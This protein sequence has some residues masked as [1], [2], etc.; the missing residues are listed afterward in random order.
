MMKEKRFLVALGALSAALAACSSEVGSPGGD[1]MG[2]DDG[3]TPGAGNGSGGSGTA[4]PGAGNGPVGTGG[5]SLSSA[6]G[7]GTPGTGG[8]GATAGSGSPPLPVGDCKPGVP[9][10]TQ[11]PKL[12]NRQYESVVRDLLGVSGL[13]GDDLPGDF[14]GAM[15]A[16]AWQAY[17]KTAAKIAAQVMSGPNKSKFITC[18]PAAAG[19]L[20]TTI[21]TFGRKAFRRQLRAE[22]VQGFEALANTTPKGTPAQVA[23]AIL[24]TFLVSPSFLLIPELATETDGMEADGV[25]P[26]YKLSSQEVAAKLSF[27][28]WGSIPDA[29]LNEAADANQ[30]QTPEQIRSQALRMIEDRAKTGPFIASFHREW[31]Q[32]NNSSGHWFNGDHDP[33]KFPDYKPE[34]KE[35]YKSELDAFFEE[36]AYT[37]GSFQDL[38][39]SNVAFVNKDNAH[40]YGLN[41]ADYGTELPGTKV[42]LEGRPGFLTRAGF[43]SSYSNYKASSPI[44]RGAFVTV[45]LLALP[46]GAP[47]P[48][49][50]KATVSGEFLT[51]RQYVEKLTETAGT[52]CAGCH[53]L[54]NP[55]GYVLEKYDAIGKVQTKDLL[56]GPIDASVT[57]ATVNFGSDASGNAVT[58]EISTP[59]QLMQEIAKIPAAQERYARAWVSY[60]YGRDMNAYD[61]CLVDEAKIQLGAGGYTILNLLSDLTTADSFRLRVRGAL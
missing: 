29:A 56:G 14:T 12:Q 45:Q 1:T 18:D 10:T 31:A 7:P 39:L 36:V 20:K 59:E 53:R 60:A 40:V 25:T 3:L 6:G 32:M 16:T 9:V 13:T 15:T 24:E 22:E 30:L 42:T 38:L 4:M 47:N 54:I 50:L 44:L 37:N 23:E 57:T 2:D 43:L 8:S 34:A 26:R 27:L 52:D 35:A 17:K 51:Q 49:A 55:P 46:I 19:C 33:A 28:L 21:E 58:K 41:P 5:G 48:E 11:I 61:Q